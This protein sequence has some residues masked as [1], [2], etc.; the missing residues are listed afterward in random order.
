MLAFRAVLTVV[1]FRSGLVIFEEAELKKD[2]EGEF[3]LLDETDNQL[4]LGVLM[5]LSFYCVLV[6]ES[7]DDEGENGLVQGFHALADE[8]VED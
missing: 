6:E 1:S 4:L 5:C 8:Q 2:V 7:I 3:G